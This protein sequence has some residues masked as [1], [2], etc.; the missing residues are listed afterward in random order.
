[1]KRQAWIRVPTLFGLWAL[2]LYALALFLAFGLAVLFFAH[3]SRAVMLAC[4]AGANSIAL[5]LGSVAA[6]KRVRAVGGGAPLSVNVLAVST[7]AVVQTLAAAPLLVA[8][9]FDSLVR[10][11][12]PWLTVLPALVAEGI[13]AWNLARTACES[14]RTTF[15]AATAFGLLL[16]GDLIVM[17]D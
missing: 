14:P 5:L 11:P 16:I 4:S 10:V 7:L 9:V 2:T 15:L 1:M 8:F 17:A 13:S 3:S 6:T 12:S